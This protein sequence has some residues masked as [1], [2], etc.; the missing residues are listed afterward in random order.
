MP[1]CDVEV[2]EVCGQSTVQGNDELGRCIGCAHTS[3]LDRALR[4]M[5]A[6]V[7]RDPLTGRYAQATTLRRQP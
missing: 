3:K 5:A 6:G 1:S 7:T 2:C 4:S